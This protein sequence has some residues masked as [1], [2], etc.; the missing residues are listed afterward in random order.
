M[1]RSAAFDL[2]A[3]RG[4]AAP[5]VGSPL[6]LAV[7]RVGARF[8]AGQVLD[9]AAQLAFYTVLALPPFLVLLTSLASFVPSTEVIEPLLARAEALMPPEAYRL[10]A[11]VVKGAVAGRSAALITAGAFTALWSASR[12]ANALRK[13]L[14]AA[15]E[16]D[17][18]RG[19]L[20]RQLVALAVT[21][22]G[23]ALLLSSVVASLV[24]TRALVA[25]SDAF[26]LKLAGQVRLWGLLRWPVAVLGLATLAALAFRTLPDTRPRPVAVWS[27]AAAATV[28]FISSTLLFSAF[29]ARF[30]HLG[31]TYGPLAGAVLLL[32]WV[33]L[34]A[35]AFVIGG[36]VTAAFPGARPRR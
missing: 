14:N 18:R 5:G 12:G 35:I 21:L 23:A 30:F 3:P 32:F 27:G 17:D 24:G 10:V 1:R 16:L 20:R 22:G 31:F 8:F 36:E 13:A 11:R 9:S 34:S 7:R 15:H 19:W 2:A 33:W 29:A 6:R 4:D 25:A 26:G 28:L